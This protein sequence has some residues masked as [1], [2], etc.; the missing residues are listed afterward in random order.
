MRAKY[1]VHGERSKYGS[2]VCDD[3]PTC[4]F[5]DVSMTSCSECDAH[6]C[7]RCHTA[8]ASCLAPHSIKNA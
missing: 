7:R 1:Q 2:C 6:T 4:T 5:H 8:C 3:I